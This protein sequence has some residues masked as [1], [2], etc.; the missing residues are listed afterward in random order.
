MRTA[1]IN[2]LIELAQKDESI[3]VLTT[4]VGFSVL[5]GFIE[6]FPD[7]YINC[8]IAEQN[9]IGVAAGLALAGKKPY[10]YSTI[11]FLA[12]RGFEQ[13]RNDVCYQNLDVTMV[14][15]GAGFVYGKLQ[16]THFAQEDI[17]ILRTLPNMHIFSPA[18]PME[19][20]Q[21]VFETH[22]IKG[23]AFIRMYKGGEKNIY[24]EPPAVEAGKP[25]VVKPGKGVAII[26]TGLCVE[27]GARVAE[28]LKNQGIDSKL[29]SL[30]T[31]KP[32]NG[33]AI[34]DEIK[35][36]P[37]VFTI[38]DHS[39]AGGMGSIVAEILAEGGYQGKFKRFGI[40]DRW[41]ADTGDFDFM[42][43]KAGLTPEIIAQQI[44]EIIN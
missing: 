29:I 31:L 12:M 43:Q 42:R 41:V 28:E 17:G 3:W 44:I 4:D 10:L 33:A 39:I 18:D 13:W 16:F 21:L 27:M 9:M 24:S 11:P 37:A 23:P 7:R 22:E 26:G 2:T 15:T 25:I 34:F 6:K 14:A 38:E 40:P 35:D 36:S 19:T 8:G 32:V 30:H 5:E 20:R 1:F